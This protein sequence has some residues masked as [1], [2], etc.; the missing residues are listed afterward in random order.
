MDRM[1][2]IAKRSFAL[3]GV[4]L[5]AVTGVSVAQ[6]RPSPSQHGAQP[7]PGEVRAPSPDGNAPS[8]S[9]GTLKAEKTPDNAWGRQA[10]T[11]GAIAIAAVLLVAL[12]AYVRRPQRQRQRQVGRRV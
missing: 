6:D 4:V 3:A 1:R 11:V 9:A 12:T 10:Y 2:S 8:P 7:N 5:L